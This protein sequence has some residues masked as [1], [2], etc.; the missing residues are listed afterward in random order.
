MKKLYLIIAMIGSMTS[1][2]AA[3]AD[4]PQPY[5]DLP[6]SKYVSL[7]GESYAAYDVNS[8]TYEL[9]IKISNKY[10]NTVSC[11]VKVPVTVV[12]KEKKEK[13]R[14]VRA[15]NVSIFPDLAYGASLPYRI[16]SSFGEDEQVISDFAASIT[17]TCHGWDVKTALPRE[18]CEDT[19]LN[20]GHEE[21]CK[22]A[23]ESSDGIH[24]VRYPRM[25]NGVYIGACE[26]R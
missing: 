25:Q 22:M 7:I 8:E 16:P 24:A 21:T 10:T 5:N 15:T 13:I 6:A 14:V 9:F 12:D 19:L 20:P 26:C 23:K 2:S 4:G 17:V 11:E 18:F 3:N 1:L